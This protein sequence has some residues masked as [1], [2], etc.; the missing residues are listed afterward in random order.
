MLNAE[1]DAVNYYNTSRSIMSQAKFNLRSRASNSAAN[2]Q[3]VLN[4]S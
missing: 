2:C 3:V 1:T 4:S